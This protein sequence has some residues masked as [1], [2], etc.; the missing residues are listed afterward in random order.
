MRWDCTVC[1][2][3]VGTFHCVSMCP[4]TSCCAEN[5]CE[6]VLSH[7]LWLLCC[8]HGEQLSFTVFYFSILFAACL[9]LMYKYGFVLT[10]LWHVYVSF[11]QQSLDAARVCFHPW[12]YPWMYTMCVRLMRV[13]LSWNSMFLHV[14][15]GVLVWMCKSVSVCVCLGCLIMFSRW[16]CGTNLLLS[17]NSSAWI[18]LS[19]QHL[20][21]H[22]APLWQ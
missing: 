19:T 4:E 1:E 14:F 7:S 16:V 11:Q 5:K 22:P 18:Q 15:S 6:C 20:L 8:L 13:C 12:V 17:V 21:L 9:P 2:D 10:V 3:T